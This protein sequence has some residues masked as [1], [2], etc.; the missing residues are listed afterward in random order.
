MQEFI[1]VSQYLDSFYVS[2]RCTKKVISDICLGVN[3]RYWVTL[4][5]KLFSVMLK[6]VQWQY[7]ILLMINAHMLATKII[8]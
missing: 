7:K 6:T 3:D 8:Q 5:S 2:Y 1:N 4:I